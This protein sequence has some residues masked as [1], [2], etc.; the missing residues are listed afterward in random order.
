MKK[1]LVPTDFSPQATAA[2]NFAVQIARK[3]NAEVLLYHVI[4]SYLTT[5]HYMSGLV[6]TTQSAEESAFMLALGIQAKQKLAVV[7][8]DEKYAGVTI[9]CYIQEGN[10]Y[11]NIAEKIAD[12]EVD[13]I[14]MGSH[15]TNAEH[16]A[17]SNADKVVRFAH[18]PVITVKSEM[19]L[20][21]IKHVVFAT[22][23]EEENDKVGGYLADFVAV[24]GAKL[25]ILR[26][27]HP[28]HVMP[29]RE[30]HTKGKVMADRNYL[31]DYEINTYADSS[32]EDGI[33]HFAEDNH[34][35][36]IMLATH[37]RSGI[38]RILHRGGSVAEGLVTHSNMLVWTCSLTNAK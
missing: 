27:N 10:F 2:L 19:N 22:S 26:V 6:E 7:A 12:K 1:I 24:V 36:M 16:Y 4:E 33:L 8:A 30:V 5:V 18:C 37:S 25:H 31:K 32:I 3:Q 35:E 28:G 15:G 21:D 13:L 20:E 14:V 23:L 34:I 29:Q 11:K 17:G 38:S 9:T